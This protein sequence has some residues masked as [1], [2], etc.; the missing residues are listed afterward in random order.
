MDN[1]YT[2]FNLPDTFF[3]RS[4]EGT[5]MSNKRT[6][7]RTGSNPNV[8]SFRGSHWRRQLWGTGARAHR[9]LPTTKFFQLTSEVRVAQS[10]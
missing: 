2:E 4:D 6:D 7:G 8:A 9:Q 5:K 3:F 10:L 1:V